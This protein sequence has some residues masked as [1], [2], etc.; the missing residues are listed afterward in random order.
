MSDARTNGGIQA[1]A[2][3]SQYVRGRKMRIDV[4]A[5]VPKQPE[6]E[7]NDSAAVNGETP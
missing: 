2:G 5:P 4:P 7:L 6:L 3:H 1:Y